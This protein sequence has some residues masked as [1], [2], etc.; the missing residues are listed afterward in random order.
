MSVWPY[1]HLKSS[2]KITFGVYL[3]V[4]ISIS[5]CITLLHFNVLFKF[6]K[7]VNINWSLAWGK[8]AGFN[9]GCFQHLYTG[10]G[11][12]YLGAPKFKL[13][14][15]TSSKHNSLFLVLEYSANLGTV[16]TIYEYFF[17]MYKLLE[18]GLISQIGR[19]IVQWFFHEKC[20]HMWKQSD[21]C[22]LYSLPNLKEG[23]FSKGRAFWILIKWKQFSVISFDKTCS[24]MLMF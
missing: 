24:K 2:V 19:R 1:S 16:S 14:S 13:Q 12:T 17:F 22:S 20:R 21:K 6:S 23:N 18:V 15:K 9:T 4:V 8:K 7:A 10:F 5:L 3:H 11:H